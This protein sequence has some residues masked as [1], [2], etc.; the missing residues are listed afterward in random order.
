MV[1][2]LEETH[3]VVRG[4]GSIIDLRPATTNRTVELTLAGARLHIGEIDSS[5]TF[6]DHIVADAALERMM[7]RGLI[8]LRHDAVFEVTTDLDDIED[9]RA[10]AETLRRSILR[11]EL[12]DQ[13][14][15]LVADEAEDY[16]IHTR[17]EMIIN[18]YSCYKP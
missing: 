6:G 7:N 15:A 10:H 2:A 9:L 12:L 4:G 17:R 13:V 16:L 1:H 3:R 8:T 14:E 11:D 5:S 18:R